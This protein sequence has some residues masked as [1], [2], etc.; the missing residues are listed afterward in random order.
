MNKECLFF[1]PATEMRHFDGTQVGDLVTHGDLGARAAP[2]AM[3]S[4]QLLGR[5]RVRN[6]DRVDV[7]DGDLA[8]LLTIRDAVASGGATTERLLERFAAD[9]PRENTAKFRAMLHQVCDRRNDGDA[10]LWTLKDEFT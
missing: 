10:V 8:L 6:G 1:Q 9:L 7:D 2:A 3:S 5:M 4:R